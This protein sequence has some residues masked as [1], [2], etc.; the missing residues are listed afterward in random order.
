MTRAAKPARMM[1]ASFCPIIGQAR[2]LFRTP[3][4]QEHDDEQE[5]DDDGPGVDDHLDGG[6]ELGVGQQVDAGHRKEVD[7]EPESASQGVRLKDHQAAGDQGHCTQDEKQVSIP[8]ASIPAESRLILEPIPQP[9][10]RLGL[11]GG[12]DVENQGAF[13][14]LGQFVERCST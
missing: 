3:E 11:G 4:I 6:D 9:Q 14:F 13:I 12:L 5:Q 7:D 10:L 2:G 1:P 8:Q